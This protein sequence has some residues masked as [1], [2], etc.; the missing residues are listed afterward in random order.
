MTVDFLI[1]LPDST[2]VA[3]IELD[4]AT[5]NTAERVI[6]DAK[7]S[8][9]LQSAGIMLLRFQDLPSER[10]LRQVFLE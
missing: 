6:A 2:I 8:K 10:E 3:A 1:C 4:D 7:K 9:A 5:H